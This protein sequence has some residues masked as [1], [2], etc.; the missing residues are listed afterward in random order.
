VQELSNIRARAHLLGTSAGKTPRSEAGTG[1]RDLELYFLDVHDASM[2]PLRGYMYALAG[3]GLMLPAML[4]AMLVSGTGSLS[5]PSS[6]PTLKHVR[7]LVSDRPTGVPW[8]PF[9]QLPTPL[10]GPQRSQ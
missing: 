5:A 6:A 1:R 4:P 9:V 2:R 7:L 3:F 10:C 8:L